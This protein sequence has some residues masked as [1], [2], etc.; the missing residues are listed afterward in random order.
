MS[1]STY[2]FSTNVDQQALD[3]RKIF[4]ASVEAVLPGRMVRASLIRNGDQLSAGGEVY[5]LNQNFHIAA[6]GK[7]VAGMV[8]LLKSALLIM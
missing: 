3:A 6:F 7:A 5:K 8:L 4:Q 1:E 2:C